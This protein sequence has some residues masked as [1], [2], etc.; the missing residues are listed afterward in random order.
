MARPIHSL[1]MDI[2]VTFT[3][4]AIVHRAAGNIRV[5]VLFEHPFS[6]LGGVYLAV[7]WLG[8]N[9]VS[10]LLRNPLELA[11]PVTASG[12]LHMLSLLTQM[13]AQLEV[14][15]PREDSPEAPAMTTLLAPL[16]RRPCLTPLPVL[17]SPPSAV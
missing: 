15:L 4:L 16:S 6:I 9:S 8:H 1:L 7:E 12:P 11:T 17:W 3:I 5:P 10:N 14:P 2:W 13:F